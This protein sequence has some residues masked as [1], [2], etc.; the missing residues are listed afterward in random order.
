[1]DPSWV[2]PLFNEVGEEAKAAEDAA[3]AQ[4]GENSRPVE[5]PMQVEAVESSAP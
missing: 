2:W 1:M 5:E 3:E 4:V